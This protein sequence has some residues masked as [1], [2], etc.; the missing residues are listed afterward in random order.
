MTCPPSAR[1]RPAIGQLVVAP[2][3]CCLD[4]EGAL[5]IAD[6][7][8]NRVLRVREGGEIVD[9]IGVGTGV[10]ACMLGGDDGRTLFLCA[11]PDFQEHAR[12]N[13]REANLLA[14]R[15]D[16]PHAG[17]ALTSNRRALRPFRRS[18]P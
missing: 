11:A 9:E 17:R 7:I 6:A 2:D 8:G 14:V 4:A 15:V 13:A 16:V 5:W 3:G 12:L 18:A 1:S 10:F